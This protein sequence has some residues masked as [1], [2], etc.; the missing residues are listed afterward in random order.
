M[1]L[2][3]ELIEDNVLQNNNKQIPSKQLQEPKQRDPDDYK[4]NNLY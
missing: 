1:E 2:I 3:M 4:L